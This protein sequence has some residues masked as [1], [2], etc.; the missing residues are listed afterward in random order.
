MWVQILCFCRCITSASAVAKLFLPLCRQTYYIQLYVGANIL[1]CR[2]KYVP[3]VGAKL[4]PLWAQIFCLCRRKTSASVVAKPLPLWA[5]FFCLCGCK[6]TTFNHMW[7]QKFCL[8]RQKYFPSVG[9]KLLPLW[10]Q[11]FCLYGCKFLAQIFCLCGCKLTTFNC[12][13]KMFAYVGANILHLYM[14]IFRFCRWKYFASVDTTYYIPLWA[15]NVCLLG[16]KYFVSVDA[17]LLPLWRNGL[18]ALLLHIYIGHTPMFHA[19][20]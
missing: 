16:H 20:K 3:S 17:K 15:Q 9:A 4:L 13:H 1:P 19:E 11:N 8:C 5:H 12:G 6:L 10:A 14:Q 7:V 18:H 2:C